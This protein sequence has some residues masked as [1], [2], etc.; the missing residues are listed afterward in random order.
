MIKQ[1]RLLMICYFSLIL[2]WWVW[3]QFLEPKTDSLYHQLFNLGYGLIFLAAAILA[4][5]QASHYGYLKSKVGRILILLGS[6]K[7]FSF[8]GQLI[9]VYY[10]LILGIDAPYPSLA[11][12]FYLGYIPLVAYAFL[13]LIMA[14]PSRASTLK[15]VG[16][17]VAPI[18]ILISFFILYF[19]APV[20]PD[21]STIYKSTGFNSETIFNLL[22][23]YGDVI[24]LI[25]AFLVT[26]NW[27]GFLR[28]MTIWLSLALLVT[29]AADI[30]FAYTTAANT[31][32]NGNFADL[33]FAL[34]GFLFFWALT[35]T[36]PKEIQV[37]NRSFLSQPT[38]G[39]LHFGKPTK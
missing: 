6:A 20:L 10:N 3:L 33:L 1:L 12:I 7:L 23:V 15:I 37:K 29:V 19:G 30:S 35:H 28:K 22:Y 11:D 8:W 24:V 18:L 31:Y 32:F 21:G 36:Q 26:I 38:S 17:I 27:T 2:G 9:W 13:I 25:L 34:D 14:T 16:S 5:Y 39:F 4:F